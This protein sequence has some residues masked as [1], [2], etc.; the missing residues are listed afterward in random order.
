MVGA[1]KEPAPV[2]RPAPAVAGPGFVHLHLHT[3]FS[4]REGALT[5]GRLIKMAV[6][7]RMPALAITDSDN[8][9]GALEFSEKLAKEGVQPIIGLSATLEFGDGAAFGGRF[10]RA[11]AGRASLV[12]L[13]QSERGYA[14]LMRLASRLHLDPG[15]SERP[16]LRLDRLDGLTDGLI[17][18][19]GGPGGPLDRACA[20]ERPDLA[21]RRLDRLQA[22][23]PDRLY[24]ELQR[25]GLDAERRLEPW[26]IEQAH[27]KGLPLVAANESYFAGPSDF[28]AHDA[29]LAIADGATI[30]SPDRRQAT[31]E[32]RFKTRAEMLALFADLPEATAN[33]VE[34]AR[35]CAYRPTTRK[36][37]LPVYTS[38]DGAPL[39]AVAELRRQAEEGLERRLAAHGPAPGQSVEDYR[40]RL[41]FELDTI[42]RMQFPGYFL[43]VA[44]FIKWAKAK[45]IP[46]GPG[47]GSGAG[48]LVAWSLTITDL[49]PIRFGLFFER[50]LNP[51]RV[52]M[53]DFDIDFCQTRRDE[54]IAYVRAR[55]GADRV[56][57]IITFGSFL[58]RGVVRNVGRVLEMPLGQ[59]DKLAK[60][61]PQNPAKPVTLAEAI[62]GEPRLREAAEAEPRVKTLLDVAQKLE[63]LYSNAST[64]AAG[65]VIG[66]RPLDELVPL[67]RDPASDMPATQF[68][69]KWVEPAGLVKFD[70]L[71]L[72]TLTTLSTTVELLKR[73]GVEVDL[74]AIPLDDAKTYAMLGRGE[75]VGVFQV[76]SAGMRKALVEM[77]ADRFEDI[78]AL[79]ALYRPGPMA[80]IPV[81][82]ARKLGE[83]APDYIHPLIEPVLKETF[84]V[85]IYQEQVMQIAQ[86]LAGYSLGEA[87]L[88]RR[89][90][91]KK[92]QSEM[93]QQRERFV[94]GCHDKAITTHKANEI[95]DLLAKFADYGFNKSHAAAYALIAYHTA[96]FKANHPVE[97]LAASMTLD[98]SN[99][100]KLSE[101]RNEARRLG[102]PV[103]P[104]SVQRS[105]VDFDVR[106]GDKGLSIV[107]A[108]SA[109]KGVGEAQAAAIVESRG[110]RPFAS[111]TDFARRLNPRAVNRRVLESLVAAGG[112]DALD[113]ERGHVHAGLDAILA[114][115]NRLQDERAQGQAALFGGETQEALAIPKAPP[116]SQT[117]RLSREFDAVGFFLSGHPLDAYETVIRRKKLETWASFSRKI[118]TGERASS[119]LAATVLDRAE[120]RTRSGSKM[121]VVMLSDQTGQY[122]AILFQEGLNQFRDALERG[123][124]VCVSLQANLEGEEVRARIVLVEPLEALAAKV[125]KGLRVFL[126]DPAP[127]ASLAERLKGRADARADGEVAVVVMV[128]RDRSEIELRLPGKYRVS[129]E[130]AGAIKAIP[131]VVAIEH[132]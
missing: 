74:A 20:F 30:G 23:F 78:I 53:P 66:D 97:F 121:G 119:M 29:L 45:G 72:K 28:E 112:F 75:T 21:E 101:F 24:V 52:S 40:A 32:H 85:I 59:V 34:I 3:S 54:V 36:P 6:A 87:D 50:F 18:L 19:T 110:E 42:V 99:T 95:F 56:A 58:A 80:N 27:A 64:H 10:E 100:D 81:Y 131:G 65:I 1:C 132:M 118:R 123:A 5:I 70:F 47:R 55:Y 122:E 63:G 31:P 103:E 15:P 120:R 44:D 127:V 12:L 109:V 90:M 106:D 84:G 83:E 130:I 115:A 102:I 129:P 82:C 114:T 14:H 69:M 26:L 61:V 73:R 108:L 79:V 2:S 126:R 35:R 41:A 39:D 124:N 60:M 46:V 92:I 57:Q 91:G 94:R 116:W 117:E 71:G 16:H 25:H 11:E 125:G 37:I 107:Y 111:L 43:I 67:Y 77:R 33:T 98:K 96:W 13:A 38:E 48:S 76:E 113:R 51:E 17:A 68:N 7:D 8:L 89:A 105:R 88:L 93:A 128:E 49:D 104:P 22:L 86:I 62:E 4:L 9:F